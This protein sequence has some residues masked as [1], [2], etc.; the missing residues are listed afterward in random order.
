MQPFLDD[1]PMSD[2][3]AIGGDAATK[4]AE[5]KKKKAKDNENQIR[6]F[7]SLTIDKVVTDQT[8]ENIINIGGI[9]LDK[10]SLGCLTGFL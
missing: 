6:Y 4:K 9:A 1:D 3:A 8:K 10:I 5:K 2:M 7:R